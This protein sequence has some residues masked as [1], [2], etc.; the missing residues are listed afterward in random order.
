LDAVLQ[1]DIGTLIHARPVAA[2]KA[3]CAI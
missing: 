1:L 2:W 3:E